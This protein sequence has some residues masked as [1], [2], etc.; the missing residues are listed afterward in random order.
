VVEEVQS[1]K[2]PVVDQAARKSSKGG[3]KKPKKGKKANLVKKESM[4]MNLDL[5]DEAI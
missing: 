3:S 1:P 2:S 5:D 4:L